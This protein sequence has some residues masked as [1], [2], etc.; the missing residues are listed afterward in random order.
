MKPHRDLTRAGKLRRL[1][2]LAVA[3]LSRYD[4]KGP[5]LAFQCFE[6][7]LLNRVT[8]ASGERFMLRLATPGWRT[9]E[10][11]KAEASWLEAPRLG[12]SVPVPRIVPARSGESVLPVRLPGVPDTCS[13]RP[14]ATAV[15]SWPRG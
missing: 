15:A 5:K 12:T 14:G 9:L 3:A 1:H 7:N 8:T 2:N 11:L 10:D 13:S 4:L 6:T